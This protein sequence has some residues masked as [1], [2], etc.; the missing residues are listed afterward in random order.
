MSLIFLTAEK[1]GIQGEELLTKPRVV[2]LEVTDIKYIKSRVDRATDAVL[3]SVVKTSVGGR[4]ATLELWVTET[5]AQIE[6]ARD[7]LSANVF[8]QDKELGMT[9]AGTTQGAGTSITK[10]LSEFT[11]IGAGATEA[12]TLDAAVAGKT[13]VI[14][15]NDAAADDLEIFPAVGEFIGSLAVNVKLTIPG[16]SKAHLYCRV[17]GTWL[18]S[19]L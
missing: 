9:A 1:L 6:V 8:A 18:I 5:P 4:G 11:T 10:Y 19:Q 17:D 7:P 16:N 3:G 12:G 15:N 14:L 2:S 13:R